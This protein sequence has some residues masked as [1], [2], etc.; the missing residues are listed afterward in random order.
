MATAYD[1]VMLRNPDI[2][3]FGRTNHHEPHKVFGI[4]QADR[5]FHLYA[6]GQTGTGK[7]SLLETLAIQD[8]RAGR[9]V[10]VID[11]HGDLVERLAANIP[12][13]RRPD[14]IYLNVP[15]PTQPY[16][17]N[18]LRKVRP[19][20]I[21]LAAS[22]LLEAM[23]KLWQHEWGVRME[24][25]LRNSLYA[26]LEYGE[27][28]L[29]DVLR[30][31]TDKGFRSRVLSRVTN[32]QVRE[33]WLKEFP[34]YNPRYRQEAISP[35]QNKIGAFLAD[36]KLHRILTNPKE[37][38]RIR[39][40]MDAG[41]ILL[42]NLSRGDLGEDSAGLLGALLVTTI[43]LAAF[44]R[45][46][47]PEEARRPFYLYLDEFQSFTTASIA[48]MVSEL[49]KYKVALTLA[50]QHVHQLEPDVRHAV[51]GNAGTVIAFRLGAEDATLFAKEFAHVFSAD[52]FVTLPN[53]HAYI[54]LM[55]DGSPSKAFS[56]TT[57]HPIT[58]EKQGT[59][60]S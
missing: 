20:R 55:I 23:K 27:A 31:L 26:L 10:G 53:H 34:N 43:S 51:L 57:L 38:I 32:Q 21:P 40:A 6:I 24:H 36:P 60:G 58:L 59:A 1:V 46:D 25:I 35:I 14:L 9:G 11:P 50:H 22:G 30:I 5:L 44:S 2:S 42:V 37:D 16:G 13:I 48:S 17:Y 54:R 29:P 28:T 49:R 52:D 33:F 19:D 18:P 41:K 8:I 7:S 12:E 3:Y 4:R 47:A 15:D 56:S 45:S 39:H